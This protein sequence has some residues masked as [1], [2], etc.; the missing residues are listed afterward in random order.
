MINRTPFRTMEIQS[1]IAKRLRLALIENT[2][3]GFRQPVLEHKPLQPPLR[4]IDIQ[5]RELKGRGNLGYLGNPPGEADR[6]FC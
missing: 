1:V 4:V 3:S 5:D 2:L 6:R